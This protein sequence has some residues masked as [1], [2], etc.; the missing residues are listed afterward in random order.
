MWSSRQR[1]ERPQGHNDMVRKARVLL[2]TS[3]MMFREGVTALLRQRGEIESVSEA[4]TAREA[5]E[6]AKL[7]RPDVVL[8]DIAVPD[9][10]GPEIIR[11]LKDANPDVMILILTM[12]EDP[13]L[14]SRYLKRGAAGFVASN[15]GVEQLQEVIR[16]TLSRQPRRL[17]AA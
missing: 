6:K 2:C 4:S 15:A 10:T 17:E 12:W 11:R 13:A 8:M 3:Y 5:V 9:L 16:T 1:G 14:I 7:L